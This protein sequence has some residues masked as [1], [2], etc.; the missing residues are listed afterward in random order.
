MAHFLQGELPNTSKM[1]HTFHFEDTFNS[2]VV[3]FFVKLK[4]CLIPEFCSLRDMGQIVTSFL[5]LDF[6]IHLNVS[7]DLT[8]TGKNWTLFLQMGLSFLLEQAQ[9]I[10]YDD[11]AD[12]KYRCN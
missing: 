9:P 7:F 1:N 2:E 8:T 3:S 5:D 10:Q 11:K 6:I 12:Y 4:I